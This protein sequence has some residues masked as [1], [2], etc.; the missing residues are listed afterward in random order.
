MCPRLRAARI[1][2]A[3][4]AISRSA[5]WRATSRRTPSICS[6]VRRMASSRRVAIGI[7]PDGEEQAGNVPGAHARD[8]HL[9]VIVLFAEVVAFIDDHLRGVVVQIDHHGALQQAIHAGGVDLGLGGRR[10][11]QKQQKSEPVHDAGL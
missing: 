7:G 10:K 9:A 8:V 3:V 2:A 5:G 1:S 6:K 11:S 4:V